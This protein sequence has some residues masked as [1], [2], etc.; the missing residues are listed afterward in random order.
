MELNDLHKAPEAEADVTTASDPVAPA[1]QPSA[2]QTDAAP[3]TPSQVLNEPAEAEAE[4]A[5]AEA[6]HVM[7]RPEVMARLR[8]LA[9]DDAANVA[10]DEVGRLKQLFYQQHNDL[11]AAARTDAPA[12]EGE[13]TPAQTEPFVDPDE[14]ELK[15][16]LAE[17]KEKKATLRA[18]QE[19]AREA[20][21]VRKQA[22]IDELMSMSSDTDNVNRHYNRVKDLQVEFKAVGEVPAPKAAEIWKKYQEAVEHFYDQWKVNKELRDYDFK[23]NLAEKQLI[24]EEATKMAEDETGDIVTSFKRLQD[25]HEKWRETGPVAKEVREETWARFKE[26]S[27]TINKRYQ[28]FFEERKA[29]EKANEDAKAELCD[30]AEAIDFSEAKTYNAWETLTKEV[31]DLQAQ[32]KTIGFASRKVNTALFN[33]FRE[34]CDKFFAAKAAFYKT[35]KD[36]LAENLAKKTALCE[37]AEA[38]REST[39]WRNT[40]DELVK[41]QKEWKTIGP[42]PKRHSDAIWH[43]FQDA[44]D[45][46]FDR[47]KKEVTDTRSEER[48]NLKAK[49]EILDALKALNSD[50]SA[51]PRAEAV[52]AV[53]ELR[54]KWQTIGFV[55]YRE[56]DKLQE[57]YRTVVGELFDKLDLN[58]SRTRREA[59]TFASVKPES[60]T[61]R[62]RERIA[63]ALE[64]RR[65]ELKTYENNLGFLSSKSKS[66]DAMLREME[67][68]MQGLRDEIAQLT[69][70]I[71]QIDKAAQE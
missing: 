36:E 31:L 37:Q 6:A 22:I 51:T 26:A 52:N 27:A 69:E 8:E 28:A 40:T 44:C 33:R 19:A 14:D 9:A 1:V 61:G 21:L 65:S 29:G 63:R 10:T 49:R 3:S 64:Q 53:K 45:Y 4:I 24:I 46:F 5:A 57:A 59:R 18:E 48:A 13:E 60:A 38:L 15:A 11:L 41:I 66:G 34:A 23:K 67:R 16:L 58:E 32:W 47:K 2:S 30:K 20:N 42:V 62:D 7:A 55:P 68:K 17:I 54:A 50:D 39:D 25:L 35:M 12:A 56:K 70:K 71:A 43:R